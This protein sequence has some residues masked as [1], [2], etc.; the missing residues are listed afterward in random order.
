MVDW[1]RVGKGSVILV[2]SDGEMVGSPS[3]GE[4]DC[5][6]PLG[7]VLER[8][9]EDMWEVYPYKNNHIRKYTGETVLISI[10]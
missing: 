4:K 10:A 5:V 6:T 8:S 7:N 2:N 9:V 3:I 1:R